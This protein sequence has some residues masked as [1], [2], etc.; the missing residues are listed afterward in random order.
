MEKIKSTQLTWYFTRSLVLF[1]FGLIAI[2]GLFALLLNSGANRGMLLPADAGAKDASTE[3]TRQEQATSFLS[4]IHP[5]TY[6]YIAVNDENELIQSSFSKADLPKKMEYYVNQGSGTKGNTRWVQY[7]DG[8]RCIFI[9]QYKTS[10]S[11]KF[12]RENL[13]SAEYFLF[14]VFF[15]VLL[16][17]IVVFIRHLSKKFKKAIRKM[18]DASEQIRKNDLSTSILAN[19]GI[20]EFDET[21]KSMELLRSELGQSIEEQWR[22][23]QQRQEELA[24][25]VHDIKTPLTIV[26]GNAE[27]LLEE[28]E[29]V[30]S[31]ELLTAIIGSGQR[32]KS[33]VDGLQTVVNME[34][35]QPDKKELESEVLLEKTKALLL[36]IAKNKNIEIVID[37]PKS[38][39]F[40]GD[41]ELI[42]R[43]LVNIGENAIRYT[44]NK[45]HIQFQVLANEED[46]T[47]LIKD[48]GIGFSQEAIQHAKEMLWQ[49]DKGRTASENYGIGLAIADHVARIHGG[50]L[51]IENTSSGGL[52]FFK[53][54]LSNQVQHFIKEDFIRC[55]P[56]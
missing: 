28:N 15:F 47:F 20:R 10:F 48:E 43:G 1:G 31:Q 4:D 37:V 11:N 39:I 9:W 5:T 53:L 32:V 13:P 50:G 3:I 24:A 14:G 6:D 21:L 51:E 27:L 26:N 40:Q 12:L 46:V 23:Q 17:Y 2:A 33:Y 29:S 7:S 38:V 22:T 34:I 35:R 49:E 19:S 45:G 52:V 55:F 8:S 16:I 42:L 44:P 25:L 41:E 56:T 54:E 18:E 36:P 30:E